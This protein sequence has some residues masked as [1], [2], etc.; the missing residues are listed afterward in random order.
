LSMGKGSCFPP[1]ENS[2]QPL[3][4]IENIVLS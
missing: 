4:Q 1:W 2:V 3:D